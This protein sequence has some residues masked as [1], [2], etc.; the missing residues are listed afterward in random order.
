MTG[1][2]DTIE[3][4]VNISMTTES[5]KAIVD[6]TKRLVGRNEEGR[7]RVDTADAVGKMI[8]LFLLETDFEAYVIDQGN[9]PPL[10]NH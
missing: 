1:Q 9:Y 4:H 6:N 10:E 2:I 3:V 7:Y 5:L 8:S